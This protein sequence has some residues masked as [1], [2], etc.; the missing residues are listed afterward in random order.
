MFA[1]LIVLA[2]QQEEELKP[3]RKGYNDVAP[4]PHHDDSLGITLGRKWEHVATLCNNK[5]DEFITAH[6]YDYDWVVSIEIVYKE[7]V[8]I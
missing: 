3:M 1:S 4:P 8:Y 7:N 2:K 6:K 5:F